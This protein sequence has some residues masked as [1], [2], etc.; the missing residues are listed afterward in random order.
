MGELSVSD[1]SFMSIRRL[2]RARGVPPIHAFTARIL[3]LFNITRRVEP[4]L[5]AGLLDVRS[6]IQ[7]EQA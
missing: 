6:I 3:S 1:K 4:Y 7:S 5:I 2:M